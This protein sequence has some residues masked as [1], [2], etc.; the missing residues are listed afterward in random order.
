MTAASIKDESLPAPESPEETFRAAMRTIL[1]PTS[2]LSCET[3]RGEIVSCVVNTVFP[4]SAAVPSVGVSLD[5]NSRTCRH[6]LDTGTFWISFFAD[7][8]RD[9]MY[10]VAGAATTVRSDVAGLPDP[11][12]QPI[13][14][15]D[16]TAFRCVLARQL[17]A[18]DHVLVIG[19]VTG[20]RVGETECLSL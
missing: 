10:E 15:N 11:A 4:V 5:V 9:H 1:Q 13:M 2:L 3:D 8:D 17:T 20:I 6:V 19:E 16:A 18:W 14:S 7:D 12:G